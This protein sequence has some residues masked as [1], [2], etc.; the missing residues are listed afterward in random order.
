MTMNI[1]G[2]DKRQLTKLESMSWA[3][4]Y[5][6]SGE[7]LI[8]TTN[9]HGFANFELY[10]VDVNGEHAPVRVTDTEGFDG[11]PA[12][13]P[14]GKA[15]TW[16][17]NRNG[18]KQSQIFMADWNHAAALKAVGKKTRDEAVGGLW[19]TRPEVDPIAAA[20]RSVKASEVAFK[21][22]D[23]M[24]H[25]DYLCR[26]ELAGRFTGSPGEQ[27]A[28]SYVAAIFDQLGLEPV[29]GKDEWFQKFEFTAGVDLGENNLLKQ[30]GA[31][32]DKE[33]LQVGTDWQPLAFSKTGEVEAAEVVFAGYGIVAPKDGDLEEY[34]SY[35]HLD[36]KD[37]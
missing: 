32:Q 20:A 24:R 29:I 28:T 31:E 14:D 6:P 15:L 34:D 18:S 1:D 13:T 17:T 35:V 4:F 10:L 19:H 33:R 16:T 30:V 21:A 26:P 25:V 5:H 37:K 27:L 23:M 22:T 11:L 36:V 2:T 7:Y 3:P 12:F 9:V 8:F